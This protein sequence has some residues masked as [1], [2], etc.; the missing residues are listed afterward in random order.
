[1]TYSNQ[2]LIACLIPLALLGVPAVLMALACGI[3][4][5]FD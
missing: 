3:A 2:A 5:L 1:M 4:C